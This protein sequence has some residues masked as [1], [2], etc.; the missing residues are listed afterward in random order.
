MVT[1]KDCGTEMVSFSDETEVLIG[2]RLAASTENPTG[3]PVQSTGLVCP[4]CRTGRIVINEDISLE[5]VL[6]R[7]DDEFEERVGEY[8]ELMKAKFG[9]NDAE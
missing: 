1:C 8:R 9:V 7:S 2:G 3:V 6:L 4:Q 5:E